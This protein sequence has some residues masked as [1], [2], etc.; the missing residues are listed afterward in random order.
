MFC[1]N[2]GAKLPD[3]AK[4][5][6]KCGEKISPDPKENVMNTSIPMSFN[7]E[8]NEDVNTVDEIEE[9][10]TVQYEEEKSNIQSSDINKEEEGY[11]EDEEEE[12]EEEEETIENDLSQLSAASDNT[13][14]KN[15]NATETSGYMVNGN[16]LDPLS[17][18]YWDD[19][20]PEINNEINQLPKDYILKGVGVVAALFVVMAWLIFFT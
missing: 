2:C 1:M 16:A 17:D 6:N 13:S 7:E 8:D 4:F 11:D 14:H 18:P 10:V 9:G 15:V 3:T 19:V 5:C 12:Y 20:L